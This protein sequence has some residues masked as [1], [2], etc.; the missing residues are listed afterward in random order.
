MTRRDVVLLD[1][2]GTLFQERESRDQVYVR[3]FAATGIDVD[4]DVM[5]ALRRDV[6]AALLAERRDVVP[7]TAP[8]FREFLSRLLA[9]TGRRADPET[10][11][12]TLADHFGRPENFVVHADAPPALEELLARGVRLGIVSNWSEQL[13]ALLQALD[14]W[15]PFEVVAVSAAVGRTKPDPA[16]FRWALDRLGARPEQALHV[17]DQPVLDVA[18][19]RRAGLAALL[20][21]REAPA[22]APPDTLR[23]LE[24]LPSRLDA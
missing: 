1:A 15:R 14:L 21:D 23:S 16:L 11:R 10:L 9:R 19:A 17:G 6:H 18:A 12:A 2:G 4:L 20:I 24:E 13:P 7:Y 3:V 22:G 8:W 5:A